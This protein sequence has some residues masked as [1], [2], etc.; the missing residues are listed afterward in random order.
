MAEELAQKYASAV[1][2]LEQGLT[3]RPD[4]YDIPDAS[5]YDLNTCL[6]ES[7]VTLN[8]FL[9]ALPEDQLSDLLASLK[10]HGIMSPKRASTG[11]ESCP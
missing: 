1:E 4:H 10:E 11:P 3:P 5:H 9:H 7:V 6:R 8:C 2:T